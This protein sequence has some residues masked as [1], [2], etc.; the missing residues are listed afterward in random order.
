M[1]CDK[2]WS[3][4]IAP[5]A[6]AHS[7][8]CGAT[9]IVPQ[10]TRVKSVLPLS[11]Q[12]VKSPV[13]NPPLVTKLIALAGPAWPRASV[14]ARTPTTVH[15]I[16]VHRCLNGCFVSAACRF[17]RRSI[18]KSLPFFTSHAPGVGSTSRAYN[19]QSYTEDSRYALYRSCEILQHL[20]ILQHEVSSN[21]HTDEARS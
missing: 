11:V 15:H 1:A 12:P 10:S 17:I 7:P 8:V 6:A 18:T 19:S 3:L 9:T 16:M 13:S 4:P 20:E 21:A 2:V 14:S 5:R